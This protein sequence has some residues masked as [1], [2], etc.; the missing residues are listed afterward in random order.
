QKTEKDNI[1]KGTPRLKRRKTGER[2]ELIHHRFD[3]TA[4]HV[5]RIGQ[6]GPPD[7]EGR[8]VERGHQGRVQL[9]S[10]GPEWLRPKDRPGCAA[11]VEPEAGHLL[12]HPAEVGWVDADERRRPPRRGARLP[13]PQ[14]TAGSEKGRVVGERPWRHGRR[15]DW[16]DE[17]GRGSERDGVPIAGQRVRE[18]TGDGG[19]E[20]LLHQRFHLIPY[21]DKLALKEASWYAFD[22]CHE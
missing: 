6:P 1:L 22:L 7:G 4:V 21:A 18:P 14:G 19:R 5:L 2:L 17:G 9:P 8:T 11:R 16:D 12:N 3:S 20:V 15:R 10:T 13:L